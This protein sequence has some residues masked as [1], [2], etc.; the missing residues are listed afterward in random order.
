M[1]N[2][3]PLKNDLSMVK[4]LLHYIFVL[5][6]VVC[7]FW[8]LAQPANDFQCN[9]NH[10]GLLPSPSPCTPTGPGYNFGSFVSA[11]G[12]TTG[13][14]NDSL[15]G[16][17][18][19]C[20]TSLLKD[21][22]FEFTA[23]ET[24]AMIVIKGVGSTPLTNAYVGLY[25][26]VTG[27]CVGLMPRQCHASSGVALDTFEFGP[28]AF[29][30][31]Y[32]LQIASTTAAGAGN[33]SLAVRS[34]SI[35]AD[36]MKNSILLAYPLPVQAA[37]PPDTTVGF[38]YS[39]VGYNELYGNRLHGVVPLLG[40][41]WDATTLTPLT[42]PGSADGAGQW[43]WFNNINIH[44]STETGVFYDI[45]SDND[46]TNNIGDHGGITHVWTTCFTV[47][48]Q[49]KVLCDGGLDD[50]SIRFI[51]YSDAESGALVTSQDCAGDADYVFDA[52][53]NC[54]Q[55]PLY[56][57]STAAGCNGMSNG[58]VNAY[59][60]SFS[61]AGYTYDLYNNAGFQIDSY[62]SATGVYSNTSVPPGNYY[63]Y[64]TDHA[65]GCQTAVNMLVNGPLIYQLT[66]TT[67]GCG[68]SC[69]NEAQLNIT[70]GAAAS[71]SWNGGASG[72]GMTASGLCGGW[73]HIT[74]VDT[75][76]FACTIND[77]IY[78]TNLPFGNP[79]FEYN[80]TYYCT[81]DTFAVVTSF[82]AAT[83]G[84]F[85]LAS[86]SVSNVIDPVTGR[87]NLVNA[88]TMYIKYQSPAPCFS[89][90]FDTIFVDVS[91]APVSLPDYIDHTIC[92]GTTGPVFFNSNVSEKIIWYNDTMST[93]GFQLPGNSFDPF[94][95]ATPTVGNYV[96]YVTQENASVSSCESPSK[97]IHINVYN[98]PVIDAGND[99]SVCAGYGVRLEATGGNAYSW[100][101]ASLL[102][103]AT[104]PN[105]LASP[106]SS[107]LFYCNGTDFTSGCSA[108]DS[109]M[110]YLDTISGCGLI[111]YTGFTPNGDGNNDF[112]YIDGIVSDPENVVSV[113][114]RWGEKIWERKNYDNLL[115]RWDG[116]NSNGEIVP[117]GTYYFI[118]NYKNEP[119]TGWLELTR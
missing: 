79:E 68:A 38:C 55:K 6:V 5:L 116:K 1:L 12:T 21:V 39:V 103:N 52:H 36:C 86:G 104:V 84:T 75:G 66:Q 71:V 4:N 22:W 85:S 69:A 26:S 60:G 61:L 109:V 77:S 98:P 87:V 37:Y 100:S 34:K 27:E 90:A 15:S 83:G 17:I 88:G 44:G 8:G 73:N 18:S 111:V 91:P 31:K 72:T 56:A 50:L 28:L 11:T 16:F 113:F 23:S 62:T 95:G 9:P 97:P 24:H 115:T 25:E 13:A 117:D 112:W 64:V 57:Y 102:D 51:N 92:G 63:L 67:F 118:V 46:P 101:P 53:M 93:I 74:I 47:K 33:F 7:P 49:K 119:I 76:S 80:Q 78:I 32:F 70:S 114:N 105:P 82:P 40:S 48:T 58:S 30:V 29:G 42:L 65:A 89:V 108:T 2:F 35:C 59:G 107:T 19:T 3:I 10:L 99:V 14:T 43:K 94:F 45:G 41:G 106:V 54:C 110:V 20:T 81:A 96:F